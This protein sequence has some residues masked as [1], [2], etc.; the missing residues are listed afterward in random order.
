LRRYQRYL[1]RARE[2]GAT[3]AKLIS[4]RSV[5]TAEWVRMKCQFGCG[6]YGRR[7]SCPPNSPTP[8][9]TARMLAEYENAILVHVDDESSVD[10]M[11]TTLERELFLDGYFKAF[12]FAAGPCYLCQSCAKHCRHPAKARPSMEASGIDV[13][14]TARKHGLP[15]ETLR[16]R[17]CGHDY[18]GL[19]L[20]E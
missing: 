4:A 13:F 16:S 6:G 9:R 2:L 8:D 1:K 18:Y 17:G 14:S 12:A 11:V 7:L 10:G 5:V 3:D 15:I 19:V 20:I